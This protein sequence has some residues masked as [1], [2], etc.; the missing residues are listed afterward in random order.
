MPSYALS[1]AADADLE[2]I[3]RRSVE[4]W[5]FARAEAYLLTLHQAFE[6][7]AA[8][9]D[10]GRS[11]DDVRRGYFRFESES[12]VAFYRKETSGILI[13]RVLHQRMQ[14]ER[15]LPG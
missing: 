11:I 9:P 15:H 8:F 10:L 3:A 1:K 14:P 7:L 6:R 4:Q 13:V 12:H 2:Q 5:G